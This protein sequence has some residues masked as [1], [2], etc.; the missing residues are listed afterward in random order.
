MGEKEQG[1]VIQIT[2]VGAEKRGN[3]IYGAK[4]QTF[5]TREIKS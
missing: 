1:T 5:Q 2:C 3:L 4:V